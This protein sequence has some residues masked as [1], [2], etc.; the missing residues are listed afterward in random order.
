M[1]PN[2]EKDS[3]NF[4]KLQDTRPALEI[5]QIADSQVPKATP[6]HYKTQVF[7]ELFDVFMTY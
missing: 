3:L 5:V 1:P 6:I 2:Q 7:P 4:V